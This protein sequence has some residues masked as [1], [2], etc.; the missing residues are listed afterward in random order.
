MV[1]TI[2]SMQRAE[3][4]T[5]APNATSRGKLAVRNLLALMTF[6]VLA[7]PFSLH[8]LSDPDVP[9]PPHDRTQLPN[10]HAVHSYL[11]RG[12]QPTGAGLAELKQMGVSTIIDLRRNKLNIEL[13]RIQAQRL[14]LKYISLPMGNFIPSANKQ[15]LFF[16]V[17]NSA[18][19]NP[20]SGP[21]FLHCSHGSDRTSFMVAMWRVQHDGWTIA[22]AAI[23]MVRKGFI[24]HKFRKEDRNKPMF[25]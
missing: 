21:V 24:I 16:Q 15:A 25:D 2:S 13:E 6:T 7:Y 11:Y 10:F 23:E 8:K 22:E 19:A 12:G 17:M 3:V 18:S 1:V 14:G 5:S 4:S 20:S 9:T